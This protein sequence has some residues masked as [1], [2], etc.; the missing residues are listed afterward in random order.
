M[1]FFFIF[2]L[3]DKKLNLPLFL[4]TYN[5]LILNFSK[6]KKLYFCNIYILSHIVLKKDIKIYIG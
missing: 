2:I 4:N 3:L 5:K 6:N 1:V